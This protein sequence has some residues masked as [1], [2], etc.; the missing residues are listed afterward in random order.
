MPYCAALETRPVPISQTMQPISGDTLLAQLQWRYAVKRFDA[1]K[2]I[3]PADWKVLEEAL[4]L[5]PS[6]WG[7]QP[8]K[9]VVVTDAATKEK[10]LPLCWNQKQVVDGSHVVVFCIKK[11]LKVEEIDAY[12]RRVAQ[13]RGIAPESLQRLRDVIVGDL[14]DGA[15]NLIINQWAAN[16]VF[17]ALGNFMT[18]AALLGIDTCPMEG[19]DP[20][21]V[22]LLL[23]LA[24][25]GLA[26]TVLCAAGV[27]AADDKYA[28]LPKIRFPIDAV[29][30]RV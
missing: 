7:M 10:M 13:V 20:P 4:V 29:I 17:I 15:R 2:K 16:Q 1:T 21:K 24:K 14:I 12:V 18:C 28:T 30:E 19:F 22:D 23:G 9:F 11:H 8:W 3:A 25:K 26:S 6:S 5:T 27:R